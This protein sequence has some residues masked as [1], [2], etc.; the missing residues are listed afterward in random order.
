MRY[1]RRPGEA[2]RRCARATAKAVFMM[3]ASG[4]APERFVFAVVRGDSECNET[5]LAAAVHADEL[6][7]ATEEEIRAAGAVPATRHPSGF[8]RRR[9]LSWMRQCFH[10]PIWS[11]ANEEGFH[12]LNTNIPRDYP[13]RRSATSP[14]LRRGCL[15][16]VRN[17]LSLVRGVEV[18]NIFNSGTRYSTAVGATSRTRGAREAARGHGLVPGSASRLMACIAEEHHDEQGPCWPLSVAPFAVH[19]VPLGGAETEAGAAAARYSALQDKGVN[20]LFDDREESPGVKFAGIPDLIGVPI[21]V[22][23]SARSLKAGGV[24]MKLRDKPEKTIVPLA[25]A[26][27]RLEKELRAMRDALM[28]PPQAG[29]RFPSSSVIRGSAGH[30]DAQACG[31]PRPR[32]APP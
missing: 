13:P 16:R 2:A 20:V 30:R 1:H 7:P 14:L 25:D 32:R 4:S 28:E 31:R 5:K 26:T 21:R 8:L 12:I 17:T 29:R 22:T 23:V 15:R 19:V 27:A 6:R 10:P 3:A 18:G 24:E 11:G 9:W